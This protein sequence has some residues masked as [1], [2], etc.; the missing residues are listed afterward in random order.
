MIEGGKGI[1]FKGVML[2]LLGGVRG[3]APSLSFP[4]I[5]ED[6]VRPSESLAAVAV[7]INVGNSASLLLLV[8]VIGGLSPGANLEDTGVL[9]AL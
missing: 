1:V 3:R 6:D 2:G 4:L 5:N 7:F 9:W 8:L